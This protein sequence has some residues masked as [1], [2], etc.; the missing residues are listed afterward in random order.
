M[1]T[2]A[3][4]LTLGYSSTTELA[5]FCTVA[6]LPSLQRLPPRV[7]KT[8][9]HFFCNFWLQRLV[10]LSVALEVS[11]LQA[12]HLVVA[13]IYGLSKT[14]RLLAQ[15][16]ALQGKQKTTTKQLLN[17]KHARKI[18]KKQHQNMK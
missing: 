12:D 13:N 3:L 2:R 9:L 8:V 6:C 11:T 18:D 15:T 7:F 16:R 4:I 1:G 14:D 5:T 10:W 17:N